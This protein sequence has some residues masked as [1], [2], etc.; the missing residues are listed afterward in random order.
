[1]DMDKRRST[2]QF[3]HEAALK[4]PVNPHYRGDANDVEIWHNPTMRM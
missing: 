2:Y 1:M 4:R 3:G